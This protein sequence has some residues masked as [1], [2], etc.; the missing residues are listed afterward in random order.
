ML[1]FNV[2]WFDK[3]SIKKDGN[4]MF[5][6]ISS[7]ID[8]NLFTCRRKRD[9]TAVNKELKQKENKLSESLRNIVVSYMNLHKEKFENSIFYDDEYYDSIDERIDNMI[10]NGEYGG[11]LELYIMSKIYKI[12]INVFVKN[13]KGYNLISKIGKDSNTSCNLFYNN[14]H[15]ELLC[16]K[17]EFKNL[18]N[19]SYKVWVVE[20][21]NINF[22][23]IVNSDHSDSEYEIV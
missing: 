19:N 16:I 1:M 6:A 18:F 10:E 23:E 22:E 13:G 14:N 12:Q 9:G 5:R 15:Y 21:P 3:I 17:D 7:F 4:C 2:E 20:N 11:N 8:S